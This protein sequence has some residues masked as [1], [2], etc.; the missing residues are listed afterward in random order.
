[1]VEFLIEIQLSVTKILITGECYLMIPLMSSLYEL[2][3]N[4]WVI[5]QKENSNIQSENMLLIL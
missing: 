2:M 1:M 3:N 4:Y 5:R